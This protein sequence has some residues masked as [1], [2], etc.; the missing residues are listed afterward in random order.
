MK[1]N[2]TYNAETVKKFQKL[3]SGKGLT[4]SDFAAKRTLKDELTKK[5][6]RPVIDLEFDVQ[7][8]RAIAELKK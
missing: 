4:L 2:P 3:L 7:L 5:E 1:D 8:Q 6:A